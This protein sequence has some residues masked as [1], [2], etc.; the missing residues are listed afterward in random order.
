MEIFKPQKG[1]GFLIIIGSTIVVDILM[2]MVGY[3]SQT[4]ELVTLMQLLFIIYNIYQLYYILLYVSVKYSVDEE[5]LCI[6]GLWGMKRILIP[7]DSIERYNKGK[8]IIKGVKLS[9]YSSNYYALGR[10]VIE[11]IGTTQMYVTSNKNILYLNTSEG[12][13]AISPEGSERLENILDSRG[14]A[15]TEWESKFPKGSAIY[16]EKKFLI[17]LSI[18]STIIIILTLRPFIL[19]LGKNLPAIMP[20]NFDGKFNPVTQGT[21]KQFAFKQMTYGAL[22]MAI[23]FC[24]YYAAYFCAKYDKKTAYKFIYVSILIASAFLFIQYRILANFR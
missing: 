13:Y 7:F 17:L 23:L 20:L 14:I 18:A 22:N 21:G 8:G 1:F 11:K 10:T 19:Y 9:G 4:Y 24:M 15:M 16:K 6:S 2:F 3:L 12:N 5:K